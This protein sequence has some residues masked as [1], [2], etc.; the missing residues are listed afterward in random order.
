MRGDAVSA[1][2]TEGDRSPASGTVS[3]ERV[4]DVLL[5]FAGT[6][7]SL[8]VSEISRRLGLSKAVVYRILRSLVSRRLLSVDEAGDGRYRLGPAAATL[9]ARALRDLDLR[10]NA[11]P[12][13]RRLQ[14]E[15]GE[16]A[17]VSELVG[18]SRVY[19]DQIVSTKEIKMTVEIGRPFPLH[20]G[21][22]SR[23]ILAFASPDL[24]TQILDG[25]LEALTP[26]TIV[27]RAELEAELARNT[28]EGV[29]ASFGERQPGAVSVAAPLLA[30]DGYAIGSIS[31]CGPVD[32]FG[33]ETVRRLKP[34]VRDAAR[35]VSRK[36]GWEEKGDGGG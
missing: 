22:S 34:L 5:T 35:E 21:A 31:V 14:H 8:G 9:G 10:E 17:T 3:A 1:R 29:A 20:A 27:D 15:S 4:A 11:L 16:T 36:L 23:T 18:V 25:P 33:E 12:V 28:R 19:L 13:L 26:K 30:A 7:G 32:R 6:G 24:R 2:G